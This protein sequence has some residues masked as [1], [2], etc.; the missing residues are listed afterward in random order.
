MNETVDKYLQEYLDRQVNVD[1]V[2]SRPKNGWTTFRIGKTE[3]KLSYMT[4][5]PVCWLDTMIRDF[6]EPYVVSCDCEPWMMDCIVNSNNIHIFYNDRYVASYVID[7][8]FTRIIM[9]DIADEHDAWAEWSHDSWTD[10]R[11]ITEIKE[12]LQSK[13]DKLESLYEERDRQREERRK[14]IEE[15]N[16]RCWSEKAEDEEILGIDDE[17]YEDVL[18]PLTEEE[19]RS[20]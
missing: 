15:Y 6:G 9:K 11:D 18:E 12:D 4:D 8:D 20:I 3:F 13:L 10:G 1:S 2:L 7:K 14:E 16:L 19:I 5:L 17:D